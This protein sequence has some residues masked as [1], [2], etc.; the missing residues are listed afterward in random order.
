MGIFVT[1]LLVFKF[2]LISLPGKEFV[3]KILQFSVYI[4]V[5]DSFVFYIDF[6]SSVYFHLTT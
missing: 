4:N 6:V 2:L 3:C 5:Q 1:A